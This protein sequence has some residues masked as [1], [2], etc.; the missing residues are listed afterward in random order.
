MSTQAAHF[1]FQFAKQD[2]SI[3]W[4]F[5][6]YYPVEYELVVSWPRN[7]PARSFLSILHVFKFATYVGFKGEWGARTPEDR[8][9]TAIPIHLQAGEKP[10]PPSVLLPSKQTGVRA[11][12][13]LLCRPE[14]D[15][16][17]CSQGGSQT[18]PLL[19]SV[20]C[21]FY[22]LSIIFRMP[23][24]S[25]KH[26]L[27]NKQIKWPRKNMHSRGRGWDTAASEKKLTLLPSTC[28]PAHQP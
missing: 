10:Q 4:H 18:E 19:Y 21:I 26:G 13:S 22:L 28:R 11:R 20:P 1:T 7:Y 3:Q 2:F 9:R 25:R 16:G 27:I 24:K 17:G 15:R 12:S 8:C 5:L 6:A 14:W 23:K